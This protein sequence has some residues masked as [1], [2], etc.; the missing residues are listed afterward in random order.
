MV[1]LP[2]AQTRH[3]HATP[4]SIPAPRTYL[5]S[6]KVSAIIRSGG[7]V[8]FTCG[9]WYHCNRMLTGAPTQQSG[10]PSKCS[11]HLSAKLAGRG[12]KGTGRQPAPCPTARKLCSAETRGAPCWSTG[13]C[14]LSDS[15]R[16][17]NARAHT[18]TRCHWPAGSRSGSGS[19]SR[20]QEAGGMKQESEGSGG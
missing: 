14:C 11:R 13:S 10:P 15:D 9:A 4:S 1:Y 16:R 3:D 18:H 17:P 7:N 19:G 5:C 6:S 8:V 20:K 12:S 2:R